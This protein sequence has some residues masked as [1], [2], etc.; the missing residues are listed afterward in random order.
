MPLAAL[1]KQATDIM[2]KNLKLLRNERWENAFNETPCDDSDRDR[3]NRKATI[4][5]SVF[6]DWIV[7]S[8][9]RV[10]V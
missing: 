1:F 10:I 3:V 9:L 7:S 8:M 2:D 6:F 4:V 5:V